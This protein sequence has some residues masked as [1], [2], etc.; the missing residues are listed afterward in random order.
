MGDKR[1]I[2]RRH[3]IYYLQ[4]FD[5]DTGNLLGHL[6]DI[7][8]EGVML[9]SESPIE[10]GREF[11]MKMLLPEEYAGQKEILFTGK[12]HWSR[13]D[14]NPTFHDTG[15]SLPEIGPREREIIELLIHDFK[16]ND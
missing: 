15:F 4:V 13:Q 5:N 7:T 1:R 8:V 12:S 9:V 16:M 6:V 14:V 11:K 3:L 2:K 10:T